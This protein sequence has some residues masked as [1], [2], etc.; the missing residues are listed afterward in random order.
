VSTGAL[1]PPVQG[2]RA[3]V[4]V[5]ERVD[6]RD[7]V[8]PAEL[9]WV[10]SALGMTVRL[11]AGASLSELDALAGLA[12]RRNPRR[13]HLLVSRVLGKHLAVDP[14]VALK[15]AARLAAEVVVH[16]PR[17]DD[18]FLVFGFAETATALGQAVAAALPAS[19][20]V[21]ST[22]RPGAST[23]VFAEEH[24]HATD[25]R[26]LAPAA[27]INA[28]RTV[29]LVD[30][31]LSSGRTAVNTIR[32]LHREAP[33]PAYVVAALLDLRPMAS[34]CEFD[35]LAAELGVPVQAVSLLSGELHVPSD[36]PVRVA[37]I[38]ADADEPERPPAD[39]PAQ[40]VT[41]FW[42]PD[43]R[44]CARHGWDES[45]EAAL[46]AA[47]RPLAEELLSRIPVQDHRLLV[48]G[49]EEL[50]YAPLRLA[51]ALADLLVGTGRQVRYQSTT[52]SP[53]APIDR[54]DYAVRCALEFAAADEPERS[55]FVY[56]VR[57]GVADHIIVVTDGGITGP[58][59][60]ALRGCAPVTEVLL[61][62]DVND[63]DP[64]SL[65]VGRGS[66]PVDKVNDRDP[67]SL[68][69]G[70]GSSPVDKVNDRDPASLRVGRGSSPVDEVAPQSAGRR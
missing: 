12:L 34:R 11:D 37:G 56:N 1:L 58:M 44:L 25:H 62:D 49:T 9:G 3:S 14:A 51:A 45:D 39:N 15:A 7:L 35:L 55:S 6:G 23:I 20:C 19:V 8:V 21:L 10:A 36:A 24:S 4:E 28:P 70:R 69:V 63:R 52:R 67:A 13:A 68:R 65:R 41:A 53:V 48:L 33:H 40:L 47:I 60:D 16:S 43:T 66:S 54:D 59:V 27:V 32:A 31:E 64:A 38:I 22:R 18:G 30:D 29:V 46:D 50:M 57:P 2:Q 42:P 5:D 17:S 61:R 26:V